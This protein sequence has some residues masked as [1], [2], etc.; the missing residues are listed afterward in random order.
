MAYTLNF[1]NTCEGFLYCW[2][3]WINDNTS[4]FAWTSIL[5]GFVVFIFIA[6]QRFG[7]SRSYGFS[8]I[9]GML[10]AVYLVIL[11]LISYWVATIFIINGVLGF[12]FLINMEK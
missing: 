10:G 7:T 8:A 2:A 11:N 1:D 3:K 4:G 12:V 5:L 9:V 6:S